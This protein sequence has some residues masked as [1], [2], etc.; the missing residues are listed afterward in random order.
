MLRIMTIYLKL[1]IIVMTMCS[2]VQQI[3]VGFGP[4][5][6]SGNTD[7][8]E[9]V[10]VSPLSTNDLGACIYNSPTQNF[11][12]GNNKHT[13]SN[14]ADDNLAPSHLNGK[15]IKSFTTNGTISCVIASNDKVYCWGSTS[16]GNGSP[17][18][19]SSKV[20]VPV[21]T[22]GVLNGK[23]ITKIFMSDSNYVCVL[24]SLGEMY[25]WGKNDNGQLGNG[26][27]TDFNTPVAVNK[28][29]VLNGKTIKSVAMNSGR[30]CVIA[31]DDKVY[32]WGLG[33]KGVL[34]DGLNTTSLLPVAA[35]IPGGLT[36]KSL[37]MDANTNCAVT[38]TDLVY[39]WGEGVNSAIGDGFDINRSTPTAVNTTFLAGKIITSLSIKDSTVC[40][41]ANEKAYCWG[42]NNFG[43]MGMGNLGPS[44]V[45]VAVDVS[46]VLNG[47]NLKSIEVSEK[48]TCAISTIDKLYC[49]GINNEGNLG[50]GTIVN[51]FVPTEVDVSGVLNG[52]T[53]KNLSLTTSN[54]CV[55]ASDDEAYCW[56]SNTSGQL[57]NGNGLNVYSKVPT[58]LLKRNGL[59]GKKIKSLGGSTSSLCVIAFDD[60]LYCSGAS[61]MLSGNSHDLPQLYPMPI[62]KSTLENVP[63]AS[64]VFHSNGY[65]GKVLIQSNDGNVYGGTPGSVGFLYSTGNSRIKK[66][67]HSRLAGYCYLDNLN[68]L[69][70]NGSYPGDGQLTLDNYPRPV[71]VSGALSG[72]TIQNVAK[73]YNHTCVLAS[74]Q[75]V[76]CWGSNDNGQLGIGSNIDSNIPVAIDKGGVLNGKLIKAVFANHN[77]TCVIASDDKAYCWGL[78]TGDGTPTAKSSPVA[79]NTGVVLLNKKILN[80]TMG[81]FTVCV[82]AD[83]LAGYCWGDMPGNGTVSSLSPV[84]VKTS[85]ALLNKTIKSFTIADSLTAGD[86]HLCVLASDDQAYCWGKGSVGQLGNGNLNN[87]FE[88][89]ALYKTGVLANKTIKSVSAKLQTTC[90]LAND[91]KAYCFGKNDKYQ[92]GVGDTADSSFPAEVQY[93]P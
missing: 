62:Y 61:G 46:G 71:F 27:L 10:Y 47:V 37:S 70:C 88:P 45:P 23:I 32:C 68:V 20:P 33:T 72:L 26:T 64:P 55:I 83:N 50:N 42:K 57:G 38:V 31:S 54:S 14:T 43:R 22:T 56:G 41:L 34:G 49:W 58:A 39:C 52:K 82:V 90:V 51:S 12:W 81:V 48:I 69:Y 80:I 86:V 73:G 75:N 2:C 63:V 15:T 85:A 16:L 8:A 79:V 77:S 84:A 60:W 13:A 53:I 11:C 7:N 29:G 6:N 5:P 24:D 59:V 3:Q 93:A 18:T 19:T 21:S 76:Y 66:I 89:T 67:F 44:N 17:L 25:C 92:M 78:L 65:D 30:T 35:V 91:D 74:D 1:L 28:T 40:V 4:M 87:K 9:A 36:V